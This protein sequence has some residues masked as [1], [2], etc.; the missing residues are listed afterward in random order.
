AVEQQRI[1][2][3]LAFDR[4]AAVAGIP[5]EGVVAGSELGRVSA[6]AADHRVVALATGDGVIAGAAVDREIDQ[7]SL[8]AGG[9]DGVV[10][11]EPADGE[12]VEGAFAA[13]YRH[14]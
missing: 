8:E 3:R 11:G 6:L 14:L 4:V 1:V 13:R 2:A 7:A 9:V 12:R 10:A 5:D